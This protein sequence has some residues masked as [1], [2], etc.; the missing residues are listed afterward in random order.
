[1]EID[2]TLYESV[3]ASQ[4][5][6]S[7]SISAYEYARLIKNAMATHNPIKS[8]SVSLDIRDEE[9]LPAFLAAI[10]EGFSKVG[11]VKIMEDT[12][13]DP[14]SPTS[15]YYVGKDSCLRLFV[16]GLSG[17]AAVTTRD[18][19]VEKAFID[20]FKPYA[21][22]SGDGKGRVCTMSQ[23]K[24]G[25]LIIRELGFAGVSFEPENYL[26]E[27]GKRY[28]KVISEF[29]KKSPAGR[30]V[31]FEGPPGTGKTYLTRNLIHDLPHCRFILV[32]SHLIASL[33]DPG[34]IDTLIDE[35]SAA[36]K[37]PLVL[38]VEDADMAVNARMADNMAAISSLLNFCDGIIGSVLDIRVIATTN[39]KMTDIDHAILRPGRLCEYIHID[40]LSA[41]QANS[42]YSRLTGQ[43]AKYTKATPLCDVYADAKVPQAS[44]EF[45]ESN[46]NHFGSV[47]SHFGF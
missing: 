8:I 45:S 14:S 5:V 39:S 31:I 26:P 1:M 9:N 40:K 36:K 7:S 35:R 6:S 41:E 24:S 12:E 28:D 42:I 21:L 11:M 19:E 23:G 37:A 13:I 38:L 4:S 20:I 16:A 43:E 44:G 30:L 3:I 15:Y 27:V 33:G 32:P 29:T 25:K 2:N 17:D 10:E 18:P 47:M 34:M 46:P 22:S